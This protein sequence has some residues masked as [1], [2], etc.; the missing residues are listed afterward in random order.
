MHD[1]RTPSGVRVVCEP[2]REVGS[3]TLGVHVGVGGRDEPDALAGASHFLE[4]LLFKGTDR[5]DARTLAASVDAR[6]GEMNAYTAREHTAFH[7]RV[8]ARELEFAVDLLAEVI[9]RPSLSPDDVESERDVILDE[10]ALSEDEPEDRVHSLCIE[11]LFPGHPLGREVLGTT[12]SITAMRRDAVVRF[13]AE[14]YG[15]ANLVVAAAG[16]LD[17]GELNER[18]EA[19][20][21]G[22]PH[23]AQVPARS[24]PAA[25]P[26]P[27]AAL[28]RSTEQVHVCYGWRSLP[29]EHPDRFALAVLDHVLGSGMSSRL[30]HEIRERR[31]LAYSVYSSRSSHSDAGAFL[32]YAGC[33]PD[34][35]AELRAVLDG[36][37]DHLCAHGISAEELD[38]AKGY[39][40]GSLVLGLEDSAS[41][42][43][44]LGEGVMSRGRVVPLD[45][46]LDGI[47]AVRL[48]DVARVVASVVAGPRTVAVVGPLAAADLA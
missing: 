35:F 17:P 36:E 11:A 38:V 41:R 30:F 1:T 9:T 31:G 5:I 25:P 7:L 40:G 39:L 21:G 22:S 8:P 3:V 34:R 4:H 27:R 2:M 48:D 15:P 43:S 29:A 42:M 12:D 28:R 32:V 14:H 10:L 20:F 33:L 13:H 47:A 18:V 37:L 16:R 24:G 45:E 44:R 23:G 26:L 6:G 19:A 46:V